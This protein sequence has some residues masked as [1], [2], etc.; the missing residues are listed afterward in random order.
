MTHKIYYDRTRGQMD[1]VLTL[2]SV[3]NGKAVKIFERLPVRSGQPGYLNGGED[4]W[5]RGNGATPYGRHWLNCNPTKMVLMPKNTPFYSISSQKGTKTIFSPGLSK[6]RFDIGLHLENQFK[7][8]AG[9]CV[10]IVDT[11]EQRKQADEL[12]A[13]IVRLR[14]NEPFIE[15]EVL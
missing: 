9:C 1:G 12:L 4:D 2:Q 6:K 7:G 8:S 13:F 5:V 14:Q 11:P 10:L 15:F 3:E